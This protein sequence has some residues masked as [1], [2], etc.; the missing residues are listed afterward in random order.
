VFDVIRVWAVFN[1]KSRV[2]LCRAILN[3]QFGTGGA[4]NLLSHKAIRKVKSKKEKDFLCRFKMLKASSNN[5]CYIPGINYEEHNTEPDVYMSADGNS[6]S[7]SSSSSGATSAP[8]LAASDSSSSLFSVSSRPPALTRAKQHRGT[9][10]NNLESPPPAFKDPASA[11]A[12]FD[13]TIVEPSEELCVSLH[14]EF[15]REQRASVVFAEGLADVCA[16]SSSSPRPAD[17]VILWGAAA[18]FCPPDFDEDFDAL[19]GAGRDVFSEVRAEIARQYFGE[20]P[21]FATVFVPPPAP[22]ALAVLYVCTGRTDEP[23]IDAGAASYA[24]FCAIA[25]LVGGGSK[26]GHVV[27]SGLAATDTSSSSTRSASDVAARS[28]FFSW[29]RLRSRAP[30]DWENAVG[31]FESERRRLDQERTTTSIR[32]LTLALARFGELTERGCLSE[33]EIDVLIDVICDP[34]ADAADRARC[35]NV[36]AD[37]CFRAPPEEVELSMVSQN[38]FLRVVSENAVAPMLRMVEDGKLDVHHEIDPGDLEQDEIIAEGGQGK[39]YKG[40]LKVEEWFPLDEDDED[41][42]PGAPGASGDKTSVDVAIKVMSEY[43]NLNFS[44][45]E[46]KREIATMS[47]L[48]H[49]HLVRCFGAVTSQPEKLGYQIVCEYVGRSDATGVGGS[50][51]YMIHE[52]PLELPFERVLALSIQI[53]DALSFLHEN[54]L[55]HRDVKSSNVLVRPNWKVLVCDFGTT[56]IANPEPDREKTQMTGTLCYMAPEIFNRED[57]SFAA[58]GERFCVVPFSLRPISC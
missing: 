26:L 36:I 37:Y 12:P 16:N 34:N 53:A 40:K 15:Y 11:A 31:I 25:R 33:A 45:L 54:G 19:F 14:Y 2:K 56:R 55:M 24:A 23:C 1:T 44:M 29:K 39:V 50:L 13:L 30:S 22:D 35:A 43:T 4:K 48:R 47:M 21:L 9:S 49:E 27:M 51:D 7:L 17:C 10:K 28:I 32:T 20:M 8:M 3:M 58:D 18:G 38:V 57:Y 46:F 52:S 41:S 42:G 5:S 6:D